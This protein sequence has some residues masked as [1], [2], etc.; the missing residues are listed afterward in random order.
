MFRR[1]GLLTLPRR[2][3]HAVAGA[4]LAGTLA[5]SDAR[6][7]SDLEP[8]RDLA[9][10]D[11]AGQDAPRDLSADPDGPVMADRS[12]DGLRDTAVVFP[13]EC[14]AKDPLA[15]VQPPCPEGEQVTTTFPPECPEGCRA[16][17]L[18]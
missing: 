2:L 16:V 5:C 12:T 3:C 14:T 10:T 17:G 4:A 6:P 1:P 18:G 9:V 11:V 8:A 7:P 15:D 13:Y